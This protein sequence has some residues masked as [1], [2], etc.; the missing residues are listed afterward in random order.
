MNHEVNTLLK[1]L[2]LKDEDS[3]NRVQNQLVLLV[4]EYVVVVVVAMNFELV[5]TWLGTVKFWK[6]GQKQNLLG[7]LG[8]RQ[9]LLS[10]SLS[11]WAVYNLRKTL[12]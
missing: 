9:I 5:A 3:I 11:Q 2:V 7:G 10:Q 12:G 8:H 4:K 6:N 1:N